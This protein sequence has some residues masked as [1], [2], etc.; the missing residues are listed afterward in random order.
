[1]SYYKF[2]KRSTI[3]SIRTTGYING[4]RQDRVK[5]IKSLY[6]GCTRNVN[7]DFS[8][9]N[10]GLWVSLDGESEVDVAQAVTITIYVVQVY[11]SDLISYER[12]TDGDIKE[13]SGYE[14]KPDNLLSLYG[15]GGDN[16]DMSEYA[17]LHIQHLN[18]HPGTFWDHQQ[19]KEQD[20]LSVWSC[21]DYIN[22]GDG[23]LSID[24]VTLTYPT[25]SGESSSIDMMQ[26][27]NDGNCWMVDPWRMSEEIAENYKADGVNGDFIDW[28]SV[29]KELAAQG[30]LITDFTSGTYQVAVTYTDQDGQK[31]ESA[32]FQRRVIVGLQNLRPK[33]VSPK[34]EPRWPGPGA[35]DEQIDKYNQSLSDFQMTTLSSGDKV[36]ISWNEP[37]YSALPEG[38][39]PTY[40]LNIGRDVCEK[41]EGNDL[42]ESC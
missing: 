18:I 37:D 25:N 15:W 10:R 42:Y 23:D 11:L 5:S 14:F 22:T 19:Q 13:N 41:E 6:G 1:M 20:V 31:T 7:G 29:W 30:K 9:K 40:S 2:I 16:I 21:I 12:E 33:L 27:G 35:S 39:I 36:E 34:E 38:V 4:C 8:A 28:E 17:G 24:T 26:E 32:D 3:S